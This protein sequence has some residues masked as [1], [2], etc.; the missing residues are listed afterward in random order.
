MPLSVLPFPAFDPVLISIGPFAIRWY[1][2]AYIV[3]ILLGW[4]YARATHPQ[5]AAVGRASAADACVDFDDFIL[6]VTLG[7][8]LGGRIGYV[9]FYNFAHFA[10]HPLEIVAAVEGRHVVP[11]RLPRLRRR[12]RRC[13]RGSAALP[14]LSLG[15]ITCAVG[16]DRPVPRPPRQFHQW[17]TV[18]PADRRALGAWS[19]PAAARCRA[20]PSQ[21][22]E[23]ALE[24][25]RAVRRARGAD[26]RRRA[27][28]ARD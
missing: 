7:I 19:S 16:A 10:A 1:A 20:I 28:A 9:L 21:L 5:R 6:W 22:Y 11:W 15:D 3:G 26:A 23:A 2:L 13:S 14:I 24:G 27:Q 4:L 17:R 12:G 8:I 18:G 25:P